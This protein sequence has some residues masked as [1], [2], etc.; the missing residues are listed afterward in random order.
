VEFGEPVAPGVRTVYE[1]ELVHE[2]RTAFQHLAIYSNAHYGR[3]LV[4]DGLV[5]TTEA[6]EF[7]YHEMLVHPALA[8]RAPVERVLVVGGGDGGS[9]RRVL[10]HSPAEAVLCEIDE[11]VVRACREHLP[12]VSAGAFDD[13]RAR[14]V[15]ADGAAF[16]A[17][18]EGGFDAIIVDGSD[19]IGP[20]EVLFSEGFYGACRRALRPGGVL[21]A[22]TSSPLVQ[23]EEFR[24]AR[25]AMSCAFPVVETYLSFVPSYP[26]VVWSYTAATDGAPVSAATA[27]E[28]RARLEERQIS[29]RLYTPELQA[30]AFA[31]PAFVQDL[32]ASAVPAPLPRG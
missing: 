1:G 5:Q 24:Q 27:A 2:E 4:L 25:A 7:C 15:F 12:A 29:P 16:V 18:Q 6:D 31:L 26:G 22:Q 9:L 30:A 17:E 11:A 10:E 8:S 32:C 13:P 3:V 20:A 19:P 23:R 21:V 14:V 28:V